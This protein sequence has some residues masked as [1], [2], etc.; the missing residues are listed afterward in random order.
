MLSQS[1]YNNEKRGTWEL[2]IKEEGKVSDKIRVESFA[3]KIFCK[4]EKNV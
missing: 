4:E 1:S 2:E 3:I